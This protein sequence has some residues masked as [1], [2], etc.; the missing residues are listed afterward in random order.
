VTLG[1]REIVLVR[2]EEG[3]HAVDRACPHE[4]YPLEDGTL[5]G[6]TL[7][8]V[9]HGWRFDLR[10]GACLVAGDDVRTY[11]V[12]V[13]DG[14]IFVDVDVETTAAELDLASEALLA[15]LETGRPPLAA[16]RCARLLDLGA[17]A[18]QVARLLVRYGATHADAGLDPE[19]AAVADALEAADRLPADRSRYLL[20]DVAAGVAERLARAAPRFGPEPASSFAWADEGPRERLAALVAAGDAEEAEAVVAGMVAAGVPASEIGAGLA[21]GLARAFRGPWPLVVLARAVRLAERL[22]PDVARVVLPVAAH[23]CAVAVDAG[24]REPFRTAADAVAGH[25]ADPRRVIAS[26]ARALPPND[27]DG[28]LLVLGLALAFADAAAWAV[29]LAGTAARPLALHAEALLVALGGRP[30]AEAAAVPEAD[31]ARELASG[32]ASTARG[33]AICL[34]AARAAWTTPDPVLVSGVHRLLV[35]PKRERFTHRDVDGESLEL[36]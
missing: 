7:T 32:P 34:A 16:R 30:G 26:C 10:S 29:R 23:G 24:G 15:A 27:R 22:G 13:R 36:P 25:D 35:L 33:L 14:A 4:G 9:W 2:S 20:A 3:I 18:E 31:L 28:T 5:E 12:A 6:A 11:R 17:S 1:A 21:L 8:C 19:V